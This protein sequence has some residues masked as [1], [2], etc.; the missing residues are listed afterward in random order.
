VSSGTF[1][2]RDRVLRAIVPCP[3]C[4]FLKV[5]G[6]FIFIS[7]PVAVLGQQTSGDLDP[8]IMALALLESTQ[9][10]I[11]RGRVISYVLGGGHWSA[12][13]PPAESGR[14]VSCEAPPRKRPLVARLCYELG[15]LVVVQRFW[16]RRMPRFGATIDLGSRTGE[17]GCSQWR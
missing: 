9:A 7:M 14:S 13:R 4:P 10:I 17:F 5:G 1:L 2:Y 8:A 15:E 11:C 6:E 3:P 12:S 16:M